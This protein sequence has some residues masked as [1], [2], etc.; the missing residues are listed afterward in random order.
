M[1]TLIIRLDSPNYPLELITVFQECNAWNTLSGKG[2][3]YLKMGILNVKD[4]K[5][6]MKHHRALKTRI[7]SL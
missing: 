2:I 7:I 3:M 6:D 4:L 1:P 5:V